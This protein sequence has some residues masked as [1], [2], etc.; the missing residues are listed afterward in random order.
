MICVET[1][2]NIWMALRALP[3]RAICAH[4]PT[5]NFTAAHVYE[6]RHTRTYTGTTTFSFPFSNKWSILFNYTQQFRPVHMWRASSM[7]SPQPRIWI[8]VYAPEFVHKNNMHQS[9]RLI[10]IGKNSMGFSVFLT[11]TIESSASV[12]GEH[13]S[14]TIPQYNLLGHTQ[15]WKLNWF[16]CAILRMK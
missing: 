13:E 14:G 15:L 7:E 4:F 12:C 5:S 8:V 10:Q 16:A 11:A 6:T 9:H 1:L 2:L 3:F